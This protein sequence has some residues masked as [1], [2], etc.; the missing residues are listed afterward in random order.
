MP[1]PDL[2]DRAALPIADINGYNLLT[3]DS[4]LR[5]VLLEDLNAAP[6]IEAEPVRHGRWQYPA[7]RNSIRAATCSACG[8][9]IEQLGTFWIFC[10]RCGARMNAKEETP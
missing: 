4:C 2:I 8:R 5:V 6:T 3:M 10:P 9:R 7:G 1:K